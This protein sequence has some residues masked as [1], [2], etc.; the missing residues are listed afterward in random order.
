MA[1]LDELQQQLAAL[2]ARVD[3]LTTPPDDYYTSKYSGE[4]IDAGI[5]KTES[6][7]E[8]WPLPI[9][10][11][12][13]GADSAQLALA[14]LGGRPNR[15]LVK[16][17]YFAGGGSQL[18]FGVFPIN[19]RSKTEYTQDFGSAYGPDGWVLEGGS[20]LALKSTHMEF[21]TTGNA[22]T[23]PETKEFLSNLVG[24]QVTISCLTLDN[25][26]ATATGIVN[27]FSQ[28]TGIQ[29]AFSGGSFA[30]AVFPDV[31]V[32]VL[33]WAG[34][35]KI[36]AC[37]VEEGPVQTLAYKDSSG[38]WKLFE[39]PNYVEELACCHNY[40]IE[41]NKQRYQIPTFCIAVKGSQWYAQIPIPS[42]MRTFPAI[43]IT[44]GDIY[45][46]A[47][48]QS[49]KV[50]SMT[51]HTAVAGIAMFVLNLETPLPDGT[52]SGVLYVLGSESGDNAPR[53][54]LSAEL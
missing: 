34:T 33:R 17:W 35:G 43:Q 26:L 32:Q 51:P 42:T 21:S 44:G 27:D 12:G 45:I 14:N 5:A 20:S 40:L 13:T 24:K 9:A 38:I 31:A 1:T 52:Q 25:E 54:F 11:G 50:L 22:I 19:Q 53:I 18:G 28:S 10:S 2:S 41:L 8:S 46:E 4:E 49:A 7:P 47:N 37:K 16:N 15:N 30:F 36:V 23:Q 6:L 39:T 3:A 48:G 29:A